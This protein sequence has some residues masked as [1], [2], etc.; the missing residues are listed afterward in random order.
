[1]KFIFQNSYIWL[2]DIVI[3]KIAPVMFKLKAQ[4]SC[5]TWDDFQAYGLPMVEI[6]LQSELV[7]FDETS[8]KFDLME[9]GIGR[10]LN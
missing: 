8:Y 9:K 6:N 1:M 3:T 7:L 4:Q 2:I 10:M 5:E